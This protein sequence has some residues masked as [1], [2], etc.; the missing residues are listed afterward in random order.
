MIGY[1]QGK[2]FHK[3]PKG[4]ILMTPGGVGYSLVLPVRE[5]QNMGGTG[6]DAAYFVYTLVREDALELYGFAS[7]E[8]RSAFEVMLG[9]SKLGPKTAL[10]ILSHFDLTSLRDTVA[11]QDSYSFSKVP[12]IGQKTAQRILLELQDKLKVL[13]VSSTPGEPAQGSSWVR[14]DILAGLTNLGY[15]EAEVA[16]L[17]DE[18]LR[19]EPDLAPGEVIRVVLKRIAAKKQREK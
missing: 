13:P 9:I 1:L 8:E 12:G 7:W 4:C 11:K 10:A 6:A 5:I 18:A 16:P 14:S 3:T 17:M 19:E 15:S 2:I